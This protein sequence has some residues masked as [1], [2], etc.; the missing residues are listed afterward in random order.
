MR[1]ACL[2]IL[3][4]GALVAAGCGESDADKAEDT[5]TTAVSG[6]AVGN[7]KRVCDQLTPAAQR[8]ILGFLADNPLG[9]PSIKASDCLDAINKLHAALTP[10][11]R[12]ALENGEVGEA[13]VTGDTATVRVVGFGMTAKLQKIDGEWMITGGLFE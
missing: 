12:A 3:A 13:K 4:A 6:L 8:Q 9:F 7:E 11:Q 1:R 5:V 10:A 2:A